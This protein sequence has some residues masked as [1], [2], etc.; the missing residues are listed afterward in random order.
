[1]HYG[2]YTLALLLQQYLTPIFLEVPA[3]A[4][5]SG[6]GAKVL[7]CR[8]R[9]R[10]SSELMCPPVDAVQNVITWLRVRCGKGPKGR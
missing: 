10:A 7:L 2:Q 8:W 1:M 4:K 3:A 5:T 9:S 6:D